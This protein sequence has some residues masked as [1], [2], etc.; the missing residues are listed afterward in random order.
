MRRYTLHPAER[1]KLQQLAHQDLDA[2]ARTRSLKR[3][4]AEAREHADRQAL[5]EA[6]HRS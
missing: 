2:L 3:A 6:L 5:R 1:A 4:R